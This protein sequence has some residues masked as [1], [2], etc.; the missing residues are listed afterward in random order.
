MQKALHKPE[1]I[2]EN[3]NHYI[4]LNFEIG[5]DHFFATGQ[6]L[7]CPVTLRRKKNTGMWTK[8]LMSFNSFNDSCKFKEGIKNLI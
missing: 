5:M 1:F 4:F 6:I 7:V 2:L 8:I 3:E